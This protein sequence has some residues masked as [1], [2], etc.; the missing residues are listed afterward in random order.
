MIEFVSTPTAERLV[1]ALLHF[2]WQGTCLCLLYPVAVNLNLLRT[3]R[4]RYRFGLAIFC[5]MAVCPV[6]TFWAA[7]PVSAPPANAAAA[8]DVAIAESPQS[9]GS[10]G[11][12]GIDFLSPQTVLA[13]W[14]IGVVCLSLRLIGGYRQLRRWRTET[15]PPPSQLRFQMIALCERIGLSRIPEVRL[16]SRV[17]EAMAV[18]FWK[19]AIL[20][21]VSWATELPVSTLEA[22]IAHELAHIR[23]FDLWVNLG[24]RVVETM[25]FY[26]PAVWWLSNR[27]REERE[28]CCDELAARTTGEC[29]GYALALEGVARYLAGSHTLLGTSFLGDG[30]M[31]LL[32]RVRHVLGQSTSAKRKLWWPAGLMALMLPIG[33]Y[34]TS[35][36]AQDAPR[37]GDR[38]REE[39]EED[40]E[41]DRPREEDRERARDRDRDRPPRE[42]DR[43][44]REGDRPRDGDRER[45]RGERDRP[46]R[47]RERFRGEGDGDRPR[48]EGDRRRDNDGPLRIDRERG[49]RDL[50]REIELLREEVRQLRE[51]LRRRQGP[52][53]LRDAFFAPLEGDRPR[54]E[55]ERPRREGDR[56]RGE[57]DRPRPPREGDR[58]RGDRPAREGDRPRADRPREGDRPPREGDRPR[59]GEREE[60]RERERERHGDR[61]REERGERE[62]AREERPDRPREREREERPERPREERPERPE[63][64]VPAE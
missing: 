18:G 24:Q 33:I 31:K 23:R 14:M 55:G 9:S 27:I 15:L 26:H 19:P 62:R 25:L 60:H 21:P 53:P 51:E 30:K 35:L 45:P 41:R 47:E 42:G 11:L 52:P 8:V 56:P 16:S 5:L 10:T 7:G 4:A 48:R 34:G 13:C 64:D 32:K 54:G 40:R 6:L 36:T 50:Y 3:P 61:E 38:P 1:A 12:S 57:G 63:K 37:E 39:R 29:L 2:L 49:E 22:I 59:E 17:T 46:R 28:L 20:L 43:P 44:R 58:P